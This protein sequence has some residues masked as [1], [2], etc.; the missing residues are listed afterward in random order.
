VSFARDT[1]FVDGGV[2]DNH[3]FGPAVAE[4]LR[5]P[6]DQEV[7]RFLLYLQPDPGGPPAA[8]NGKKP[9]LLG[10]IWKG[11]SGIPSQQP[12]LNDLNAVAAYNENVRRIH[13][14]VHAEEVATQALE[15]KGGASPDCEKPE[16]LTVAQRFGCAAG[17]SAAN[18]D[19]E[20]QEASPE[21]LRETR[22]AVEEAA[23][24]GVTELAGRS[25]YSLRVHSVLDQFVA[26]IS[27][28]AV[29]NYPPES[30]HRALVARIVERWAQ[31]SGLIDDPAAPE[32]ALDP[33]AQ[34][35]TQ[36][37]F[38]K[39]FDVGYQRRQLRFV[40]DWINGQYTAKEPP[41]QVEREALD[42]L[43]AA[44]AKRIEELSRLVAGNDPDPEMI[45]QL[46]VLRRLFGSLNP[47]A[48]S[49]G[50]TQTIEVLARRFVDDGENLAALEGVR[51]NLGTA[52]QRLQQKVR[53]GSFD[54]FKMRGLGLPAPERQ[55]IL[56][57]YFGFP[58]WDRQIYPLVAFADLGEFAPIEVVRLSP[59]DAT[60]LG[61]GPAKVKLVGAHAAHFGAFLKRSGRES[62][63]VWGRLDAAERL[64]TVL[65]IPGQGAGELFRSIVEEVRTKEAKLIRGSILQK[66]EAD[67]DR[68]FPK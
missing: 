37:S 57:R 1:Y 67:I 35:E 65:G 36:L 51:K 22:L 62:D 25:Y 23:D 64:L 8:P 26:V 2:L 48:G 31:K 27:S 46:E 34:K 24:K 49:D 3:P 68:R 53:A 10:T 33:I 19:T 21:R 44:A 60:L 6:N 7:K 30:A 18:L 63:Y 45:E 40:T 12:I 52:L 38:L 9:G 55:Q 20:L 29:C 32:G 41:T 43:K 61:G 16:S 50:K 56:V 66:R 17:Y 42:E 15:R 59:D 58:F 47:W 39:D 54:D 14:I 11:L 13:D 5:R 4:V 28:E